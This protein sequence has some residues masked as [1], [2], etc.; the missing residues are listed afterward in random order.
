MEVTL[1]VRV[2]IEIAELADVLCFLRVTLRV[3]VWIEMSKAR[4]FRSSNKVTLR[5]RVWIEINV[6]GNLDSGCGR[7]PPCE[8]VD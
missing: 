8:G 4:R 3:R 5:V 6:P 7:H 2:W 1:R